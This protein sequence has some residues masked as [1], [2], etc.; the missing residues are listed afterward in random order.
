MSSNRK[1]LKKGILFTAISRYSGIIFSIVIG[2]VLARLLTPDEFGIIA[3]V[4][5]FTNFFRLL[6]NF[7][8]GPAIIQNNTITAFD[9]KVYFTLSVLI[10][11]FF[12]LIFFY[13]S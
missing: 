12:S 6:S 5:I 4:T 8:L 7:G 9:L 13:T 11:L 3:I 10:A 1:I 2:A